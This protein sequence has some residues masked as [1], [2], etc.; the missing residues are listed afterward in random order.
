MALLTVAV[1]PRHHLTFLAMSCPLTA[2]PGMH[3]NIFAS[4]IGDVWSA[5]PAGPVPKLA[6][7]TLRAPCVGV[8]AAPFFFSSS[9][10]WTICALTHTLLTG[11]RTSPVYLTGSLSSLLT[12]SSLFTLPQRGPTT[13]PSFGKQSSHNSTPLGATPKTVD[14]R[15]HSVGAP[16]ASYV[17][18]YSLDARRIP[19]SND[20]RARRARVWQ[21]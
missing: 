3:P 2:S 9:S 1:L 20:S 18:T 16:I 4:V 5:R 6:S 15:S 7:K 17:R 10:S 8:P 19:P 14:Q 13:K 12:L 21:G 11:G